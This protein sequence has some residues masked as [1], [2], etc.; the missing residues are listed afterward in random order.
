MIARYVR[1]LL[2]KRRLAKARDEVAYNRSGVLHFSQR[3]RSAKERL[4]RIEAERVNVDYPP[5]TGVSTEVV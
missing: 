5:P 3:L 2:W 1:W 4:E